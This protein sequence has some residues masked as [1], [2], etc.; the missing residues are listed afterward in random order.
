MLTAATMLTDDDSAGEFPHVMIVMTNG[1]ENQ[2]PSID[3]AFETMNEDS[4]LRLRI[5]SVGLGSEA[6]DNINGPKLE[7]IASD[8]GE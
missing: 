1:E 6:E 3:T 2:P 8:T 4:D 7:R 5:Y